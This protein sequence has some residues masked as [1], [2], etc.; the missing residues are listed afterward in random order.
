MP[1]FEAVREERIYHLVDAHAHML[2]ER[3]SFHVT[4]GLAS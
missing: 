2:V 3:P 1:Q 4:A